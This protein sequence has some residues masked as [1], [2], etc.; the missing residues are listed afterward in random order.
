MRQLS[1]NPMTSSTIDCVIKIIDNRAFL[2]GSFP[3]EEVRKSTSYY[4]DG[5]R[6]APSYN[7][8]IYDSVLKDYRRIWD[9]KVH[10]FNKKTQSM[11]AGLVHTVVQELQKL[12]E[13]AHIS[14]LDER[15]VPTIAE[16]PEAFNLNG[17]NFG[18]GNF[19]YQIKAAKA[20]IKGKQGILKMATNSGKSSIACAIIKYC[21]LPTLFLVPG[22]DLL[23][24]TRNMFSK[25][26]GMPV[27]DI[28]IIGD[29]Q[30]ITK[31]LVTIA[32]VDTLFSRKDD[33]ETF[34][35]LQ[36]IWKMVFIDECHGAGA[37][38]TFDVLELVRAHIRIGLS[39]TPLDRSDGADLKLIAQ[40]GEILYEVSN[41]ELIDRGISVPTHIEIKRIEEPVC[42]GTHYKTVHNQA[43][44]K[45]DILNNDISTWVAS[46]LIEKLQVV[47]LVRE[48]EHGKTLEKLIKSLITVPKHCQFISG[49]EETQVRIDALEAF[50]AGKVRCLIGTSILYQGIDTP[51]I[52]VL[53]FAD[54]G[55][56]KIAVLQALGRGLRQ[57]EGKTRLLV[58]DYA[59]FC[60]KWLT[61]HSLKRLQ[62]YKH[63]RCFTI[64]LAP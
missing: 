27:S 64:S 2:T 5:Y 41:K 58:R 38:T 45:N 61:K 3:L 29:G 22:V 9:G 59:N 46:K 8:K 16:H 17:I 14:I 33:V 26:L 55:K 6:F 63:E 43:V 60:H 40:T 24:Q 23:H 34:N 7:K 32:T 4:A 57:R 1:I 49:Q 36:N 13:H 18:S 37:D 19:D 39:G 15:H 28:G 56:S 35:W 47:V 10:L 42:T 51:N 21:Q 31:P 30:Y 50:N 12:D 54:L 52:D 11:P 48:I 53:V 44:V 62:M 25:Y 20:A